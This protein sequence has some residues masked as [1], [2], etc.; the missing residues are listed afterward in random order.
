MYGIP[1]EGI[2]IASPRLLVLQELREWITNLNERLST[3]EVDF[4]AILSQLHSHTGILYEMQETKAIIPAYLRALS[5][6]ARAAKAIRAELQ[7]VES[8]KQLV[9]IEAEDW[10]ELLIYLP[11]GTFYTRQDLQKVM[12]IYNMLVEAFRTIAQRTAYTIL[13]GIEDEERRIYEEAANRAQQP[14]A[15]SLPERPFGGGY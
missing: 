6:I 9:L 10:K 2:Q 14:P 11:D 8:N 4:D 13:A 1:Q 3:Q 5:V 7:Y 12:D 15:P